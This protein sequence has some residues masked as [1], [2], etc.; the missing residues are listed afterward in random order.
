MSSFV[1]V[2]RERHG[3]KSWL[4]IDSYA[5]VADRQF[6]PILGT[7]MS[8]AAL[9]MPLGFVRLKEN[10]IMVGLLSLTAG[11][12]LF[13]AADGCW[14]GSYIPA[15]FRSYP[16]RFVRMEGRREL[17]LSVDEESGLVSEEK[18][19]G[20]PF[21]E[22]SGQISKSLQGVVD[23]LNAM[24]KHRQLTDAAVSALAEAGVIAPWPIKWGEKT[25]DGL[26]RIDE[27]TL[28]EIEDTMFLKLRRAGA[29]AVA[30]GQLLSMGNV[31]ILE[32]L[33]AVRAQIPPEQSPFT[34][35][36]DDGEFIRFDE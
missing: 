1:A 29:L 4:R 18:N 19:I 8:R 31:A 2:T 3:A 34:K 21:F 22:E 7:E 16:F 28:Q 5:F 6:V 24:V 30:Y 33:A 36:S 14:G 15:A 26:Y 32:K 25:V 20:E 9:A 23:L 13:V 10:Y 12:N 17:I 11:Q 35:I 27:A